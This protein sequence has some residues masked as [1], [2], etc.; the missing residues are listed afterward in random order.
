E[1]NIKNKVPY[2]DRSNSIIEPFL[3]E[4]WFADAEK[5]SVKAKEVVNSKKTNFFPEN[6]SK[7]YFQWMNNIEPWCISR[8]LWW[9]HQIPAWYG[10]DKKIFVANNEEEA[11]KLANKHYGKDEELIRDPDVL[12]T[13]FSSGLWPF[14]TLGWPDNKDYV[15]KF[16]PTSVLVTG[17]D[18]IFFW[19]ARMIMFGLKFA[20]DVPFHQVYVHGL[21]RDS[22]GQKMSKSKGNVL[23]PLD[24]IDGIDLETLVEKR[25]AGLMQPKMAKQIAQTTRKQFPNGIPSFG[26]D[27]LR[28]TFASLATQGR[29]IRFD[30]GRIE[31]F[32]NFCN[33]LWNA[34]RFVEMNTSSVSKISGSNAPKGVAEKW[35]ESKL[36]EVC[37]S[38]EK[39]MNIY[40]FDQVAQTLHTF[41]WDEYCS[42]YLEIAKIQLAS[43]ELSPEQKD[44]VRHTLTTILDNSLRLLH[45]LMPFISETLWQRI[46]Q[47]DDEINSSVINQKYPSSDDFTVDEDSLADMEWLKS[48]IGGVRNIRG[49][50]NIDPRQMLPALLQTNNEQDQWRIKQFEWVL[51]PLARLEKLSLINDDI[52]PDGDHATALTGALKILVPMGSL[53]DRDAELA[54][55]HREIEKLSTDLAKCQ[56]KLE[57]P[58]FVERAPTDVVQKETDRVKQLNRDLD[59]FRARQQRISDMP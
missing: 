52:E 19:V 43:P 56:A 31:G 51:V 20:G 57:N 45:P 53:I 8:Q 4:Q 55:L 49:E 59:E 54:R 17:F 26:T 6:W 1:E 33:K 36:S 44:V 42:W 22:D 37:E 11:K 27:A 14:A 50:M 21:V 7:T 15:E 38:V 23:D 12:D 46:T 34:A 2:G 40:R 29:D 30:L 48:V 9:G 10:P 5:L 25:T 3:T 47:P 13:W 41:I 28:F 58:K 39:S 32:R 18:I 35:I 16:Y 24:L